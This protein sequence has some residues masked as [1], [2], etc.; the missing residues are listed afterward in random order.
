MQPVMETPAK[1]ASSSS[2]LDPVWWQ[3]VPNLDGSDEEAISGKMPTSTWKKS[4]RSWSQA[5][6]RRFISMVLDAFVTSVTYFLR[7]VKFQISQVSTVPNMSVLLLSAALTSATFSI[8]HLS[9]GK[10]GGV[11]FGVF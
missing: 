3:M 6:V 4:A 10:K 11:V 7:P 1:A 2:S 8:N 9:C 5:S